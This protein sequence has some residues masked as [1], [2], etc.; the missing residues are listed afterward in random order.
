MWPMRDAPVGVARRP[1]A[2]APRRRHRG[3]RVGHR[4]A[5]VL[6]RAGLEVDLGS[7]TREQAEELAATRAN[8][9]YL[10]GVELPTGVRPPCAPP[11]SSC[12]ATT[13]SASP[14]PPPRCP[15]RWPPTPAR[16]RRAPACSS[17][18]RASSRRSARCPPPSCPSASSWAI[19]ALGG[20][21]HGKAVARRRASLV[22][23]THEDRAFARQVGDALAAAGFDV[24]T[25]TDLVGVELAGSAKNAAALA[26]AAAATAGPNAAGAAAGKVFAEVDAYAR[27]AGSHRDLRRPG[28]HGRPRRHRAGDRLAQPPRGRA[29]RAGRLRRRDRG[30]RP[31]R[32]G[33]RLRAAARGARARR[34]R[35]RAGAEVARRTDRGTRRARPSLVGYRAQRRAAQRRPGDRVHGRSWPR[36]RWRAHPPT[37]PARRGLHRALPRAPA[38]RLLVLLL[39]GG[40]PP[41][42]RGPHGADVPAGLPALRAGAARVAGPA[43]AAVA[44]PH[45]AQPGGQLLPRPLAPAADERSTTRARCRSCTRPR[46]GRGPRGPQPHPRVRAAASGR[47]PRGADHALRAGDGQ[48]RDRACARPHR[49]RDQGAAAPSDQAAGGTGQDRGGTE[50]V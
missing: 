2:A 1:A 17:C 44:D 19:G 13:S 40:Q 11:T 39:P 21:A 8:E 46:P 43:A 22:L 34:R 25:T 49:R 38:R 16:S 23:A 12:R 18:P 29:A 15:P 45:R 3:R 42:R 27:R 7:R 31:G 28:R 41:R 32:R 10:P 47:P 9:R 33:G 50:A 24:A 4:V 5:V 37:R 30:A 6:A 26:A 36:D 14:S 48:P 20:P 35:R